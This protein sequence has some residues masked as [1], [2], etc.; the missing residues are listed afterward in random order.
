MAL[1]QSAAG[2][3]VLGIFLALLAAVGAFHFKL[4]T[5]SGAIAAFVL[6]AVTFGLGGLGWAVVLIAFFVSSN[7][8][9]FLFKK[10]K[11]S[12]ESMYSK[13]GRRDAAQVLANGGIAG[14]FVLLHHFLPD[15]WMPWLGFC[16]ALAAANADTW[17]TELGVLNPGKPISILSGKSVEPGTSGAVSLAG[18]LASL[19]GAALIAFFGWI[20][21]PNGILLSSNSFVLFAL[22]SVGG[23]IGSLV[24][25][26]LGASLQ[27]IFYCPKCQKETEKHPLH[28]CGAETHLVRGKKWM[29][30]DWVNM[31]CTISAP[32]LTIILGLI[33]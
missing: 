32:L 21:M 16:A 8:L 7:A 6:G 13:G 1:I 28:G 9:S 12:A 10:R 25:S 4:L 3:L 11:K 27:A 15:A 29:D 31:G 14:F 22:V 26:I 17:A 19:A 24:D 33:L 2:Q 18:T 30:N 20:L 23:L 5:V